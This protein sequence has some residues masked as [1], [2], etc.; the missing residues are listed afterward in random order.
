[1]AN[2]LILACRFLYDSSYPTWEGDFMKK[3]IAF[4]ACLLISG[5]AHATTGAAGTSLLGVYTTDNVPALTFGFT[6]QFG[7]FTGGSSIYKGATSGSTTVQPSAVA[8]GTLTLP[9]AT[10]TLVGKATTDTLTNKTLTSPTI[11]N[12]V[13][14]GPAPVA[15]GATCSAT[16]GQLVLL[17]LAAGSTATIPTSSGSGNVIRFR[18]TVATTS[19]Q[20]KILLNTV[21]DAIIG[22][23]VG[24]N[25]GTAKVFVGNASTY[26]SIQ[27]PFAGSQPSGG[28]IGDSVSCTDI[29]TGTWACDIQYQAGTT[30]TTPYSASTT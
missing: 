1:M 2:Y 9:A 19:A 8:S 16:A 12:A 18:I 14:T 7:N 29:A 21:T 30:P 22:T 5:S 23:A 11:N 26:H 10:D 4:A 20:E 28:F 15:C 17:N 27:M 6:D 13:L 3:F 24:E 25:A